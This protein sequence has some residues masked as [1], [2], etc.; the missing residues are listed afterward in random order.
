LI[1]KDYAKAVNILCNIGILRRTNFKCVIEAHPRPVI[2]PQELPLQNTVL[3]FLQIDSRLLG[4]LL[5]FGEIWNRECSLMKR[6]AKQ[7]EGKP[8]FEQMKRLKDA[9]NILN[10]LVQ[11]IC[12]IRTQ[13]QSTYSDEVA[14]IGYVSDPTEANFESW[15]REY[16]KKAGN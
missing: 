3:A 11:D 7:E 5:S 10:T 12:L 2:L 16:I 9:K 15:K 13:E 6:V 1:G 14:W 8:S 4:K